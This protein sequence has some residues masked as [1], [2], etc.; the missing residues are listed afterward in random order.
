MWLT[1]SVDSFLTTVVVVF[2]LDHPGSV[3]TSFVPV[4]QTCERA[5]VLSNLEES[6]VARRWSPW[7]HQAGLGGGTGVEHTHSSMQPE[8][9]SV[10]FWSLAAES[11]SISLKQP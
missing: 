2:S 9:S 6:A 8:T 11:V 3:L 4:I 5:T 1:L 10:S 7:T